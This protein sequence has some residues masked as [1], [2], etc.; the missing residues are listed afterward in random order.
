MILSVNCPLAIY[1]YM[2]YVLQLRSL[3]ERGLKV[4]CVNG[5]LQDGSIKKRVLHGEYQVVLFTP[6]MLLEKKCWR[7]M[8]CSDIYSQRMQAFVVDEAHTVKKW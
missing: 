3:S 2:Y 5:D 4:I 1:M 7:R 8:L 6:E